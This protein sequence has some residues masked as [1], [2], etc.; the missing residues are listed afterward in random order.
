MFQ[1][2]RR[3]ALGAAL[4][5]AGRAHAQAWP[6]RPITWIV[7][8]TPGG[9][10]DTSSRLVAQ[11]LGA[12]LGQQVVIDNR[13]G[14]G[15]SIGTEAGARAAA[16]G[17]TILYGTQG[18]LATNPVLYRNVRYDPLRDFAPVHGLAQT[19]LLVVVNPARPFRTLA[20][21][22]GHARERPGELTFAT[23]GIGTGTHMAAE[24]FQA[25]AGVKLTQVPY[26]GSAPALNDLVAGRTDVMFDYLVSTRAFLDAGRLRPIATTAGARLAALPEVPTM[27]EA[28]LPGAETSSWSCILAPAAVP[29]P[30]RARL[31]DGLQAALSEP[32]VVQTLAGSGSTP[33]MLAG[34]ALQDFVTR[35][36]ERWRGIVERS[37]ARAG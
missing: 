1:T 29:A 7:P 31:A 13:P 14:A 26:Q 9:I 11:P 4:V 32:R 17:Y 18:T 27:A 12:W 22:I 35:E 5:A 36:V 6:S 23:S 15:G 30:I 28:G 34:E 16:D 37:G 33:L 24:L 3:A 2:T 19:P 25:E 10:T 20:E 21:L 8:F